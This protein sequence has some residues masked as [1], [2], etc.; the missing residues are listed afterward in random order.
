MLLHVDLCIH[1]ILLIEWLKCFVR[2]SVTVAGIILWMHPANERR[3]YIVTSSLIGR[4]HTQSDPWSWV[5]KHQSYISLA[6]F[7]LGPSDAV[8]HQAI[9]WINTP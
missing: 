4:V 6:L 2:I 1:Q 9:T 8:W 7:L 5:Q 3:R